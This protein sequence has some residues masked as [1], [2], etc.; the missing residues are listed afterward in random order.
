ML[1]LCLLPGPHRG[2]KNAMNSTRA[3]ASQARQLPSPD[4]L[5]SRQEDRPQCAEGVPDHTA[6]RAAYTCCLYGVC[7]DGSECVNIQDQPS[8]RTIGGCQEMMVWAS[9]LPSN[10]PTTTAKGRG[11]LSKNQVSGSC[12]VALHLSWRQGD[13]SLLPGSHL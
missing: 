4:K 12:F 13:Q 7:R 8:T 9:S 1:A 11:S 3:V 5:P 2:L 10:W 6:A